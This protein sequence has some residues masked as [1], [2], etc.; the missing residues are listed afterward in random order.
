MN[1]VSVPVEDRHSRSGWLEVK[2]AERADEVEQA[3]R[4][5]YQVFVEEEKKFRL[6]N[7]TGIERDAYDGVCDHLI[8]KNR[9]SG[10]VV[11]TYRLLPGER[12]V[13]CGGF[14]S[15]TEFDLIAFPY[16]R[17][18]I[19]ELGRSC[20]APAY[21]SGRAIQLL[22]EGIARYIAESGHTCL[23]GCASLNARDEQELLMAYTVLKQTGVLTDRF[24]VR[25]LENHRVT[26]LRELDG[27]V[28]AAAFA[29]SLPPLVKGYAR[30]G[31][32]MAREPA[33]DPVFDTYDFFVVLEKARLSQKYRRHFQVS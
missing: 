9:E 33:Y 8:V 30:L 6:A 22:W 26:G 17:R 24:G 21:R 25:P 4:L 2:L 23:I 16:D 19:L 12:T 11:A 18:M 3:L 7:E 28:D 15:E 32:E 13:R 14:Y 20:I 1:S 31:A 5:R 29:Q 10:E 27:E